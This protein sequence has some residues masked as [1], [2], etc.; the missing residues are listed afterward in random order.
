MDS[1]MNRSS[2]DDYLANKRFLEYVCQHLLAIAWYEGP[3]SSD[4]KFTR[5]PDFIL[6]SAL[7]LEPFPEM[8]DPFLA[9]AA[10]LLLDRSNKVAR[11][12]V[13][14]DA[15]GPKAKCRIPIPFN[16]F[17]EPRSAVEDRANGRDYALI[18]LPERMHRLLRQTTTPFPRDKWAVDVDQFQQFFMVGLPAEAAEQITGRVQSRNFVTTM[19]RPEFL[20]LDRCEPHP[21]MHP[22]NAP[23]FVA[24]IVGRTDLR[25]IQ[26]M[27]GGPIIGVR[28]L[29]GG[30][31]I[32]SLVAIQSR[33][34]PERRIVIGTLMSE[35]ARDIDEA[36]AC[37]AA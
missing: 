12:H 8:T 22:S 20:V 27:S 35:I 3:V 1:E 28:H 31:A 11:D 2:S 7:L 15:W 5:Q 19:P 24:K 37:T 14:L 25:D 23:Q 32:Y 17:E 13:L 16:S 29:D 21:D 26:G 33:W 4:G 9:T 6:G 30:R 10:H 34:L 36:L 18:Q